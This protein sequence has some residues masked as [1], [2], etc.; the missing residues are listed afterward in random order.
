MKK[1][2][3]RILLGG[4]LAVGLTLPLSMPAFADHNSDCRAR[5]ESARARL[6]HDS[7]K[8]GPDSRRVDRDRDRLEEARHWCRDHHSDWDHSIFDVGVYV[9]H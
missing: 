7:G 4:A 9:R 3:V 8:Y 5:L 6:D 1:N 2:F